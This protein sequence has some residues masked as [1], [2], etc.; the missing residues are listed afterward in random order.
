M[1]LAQGLQIYFVP[2]AQ[3]FLLRL[4]RYICNI[5][6][7]TSCLSHSMSG[8]LLKI[9]WNLPTQHYK[10]GAVMPGIN[11]GKPIVQRTSLSPHQKADRFAILEARGS[12]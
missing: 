8:L 6:V 7:Q 5:S 12:Y 3:G 11:F 2:N 9:F 1:Q 4:A 10:R